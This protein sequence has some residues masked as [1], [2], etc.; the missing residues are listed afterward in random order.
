M[1]NPLLVDCPSNTW[2]KVAT[3]VTV[4]SIKIMSD[5]PNVYF[6][7]YRETGDAAPTN[8][9]IGKAFEDSADISHS[10]GI[11]VYIMAQNKDGR[12]RVDL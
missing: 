2:T 9:N 4:G 3:N 7:T 8:V 6:H 10:Q 5:T 12:V 1:S 11:D